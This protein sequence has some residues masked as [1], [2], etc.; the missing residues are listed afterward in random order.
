MKSNNIMNNTIDVFN[1][2]NDYQIDA[3]RYK[4]REAIESKMADSS[5]VKKFVFP[6][7]HGDGSY[8]GVVL[9]IVIHQFADIYSFQL[10]DFVGYGGME[11][12]LDELNDLL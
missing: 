12:I 8:A 2:M 1:N 10:D 11:Y 6:Q 7:E 9:A 3:C 4:T 5:T